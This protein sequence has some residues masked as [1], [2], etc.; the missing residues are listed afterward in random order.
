MCLQTNR[1][2]RSVSDCLENGRIDTIRAKFVFQFT[3][4]FV[5]SRADT[6]Q[7]AIVVAKKHGTP[8]LLG[9]AWRMHSAGGYLSCW[10]PC[11]GNL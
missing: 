3:A 7:I 11:L 5:F 4:C 8:E 9:C 10:K 6:L 1:S 2:P